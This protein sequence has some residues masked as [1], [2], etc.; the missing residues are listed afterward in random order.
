MSVI[1]DIYR[2]IY[3]KPCWQVEQG[4][5]SFLTFE[6]GQPS[7]HITEPHE[8]SEQAAESV[9]RN[10]ARRFVYVRGDW[11]LW[12]YICDWHIFLNNQE[13]ANHDSNRRT[14]KKALIEI[15]GQ[16]LTKVSVKDS[17]VSVFEFDLGGRLE[18]IPNHEEYEKTV[19]L[20]L[21]YEPSGNVFTLRAD[22][23]YSHMPGT[24]LPENHKWKPLRVSKP[25]KVAK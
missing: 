10:A 25:Q 7:L 17:I 5:G 21:L 15:N 12:I 14:I 18:V 3:G 13:L 19:D 1:N 11:H 2:P 16:A 20:W 8:V 24:T 23:Q 6:F 9:R 4:Y 22:G